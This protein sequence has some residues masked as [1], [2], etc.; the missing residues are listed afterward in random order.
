M[1]AQAVRLEAQWPCL[2]QTHVPVLPGDEI[3]DLV[4]ESEVRSGMPGRRFV[5]EG[6]EPLAYRVLAHPGGLEIARIDDGGQPLD[7]VY[8]PTRSFEQHPLA[9][10]QRAGCLSTQPLSPRGGTSKEI[11]YE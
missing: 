1:K 8:V 9:R 5:I 7:C 10:A 6:A 11:D 4:K 2:T 3:A